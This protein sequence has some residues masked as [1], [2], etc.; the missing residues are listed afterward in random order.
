MRTGGV[1]SH[2]FAPMEARG[3]FR[4]QRDQLGCAGWR[5]RIGPEPGLN[6]S[7]NPAVVSWRPPGGPRLV[8][9][10]SG[11]RL[12]IASS[13]RSRRPE[14]PANGVPRHQHDA[15]LVLCFMT[16]E[17]EGGEIVACGTSSNGAAGAGCPR[18][19]AQGQ[20]LAEVCV[21][22]LPP[23]QCARVVS[24]TVKDP[25]GNRCAAASLGGRGR[26]RCRDHGRVP[27]RSGTGRRRPAD[28]DRGSAPV[29]MLAITS[30]CTVTL[31]SQ[32]M[33]SA[34]T[35]LP[36]PIRTLAMRLRSLLWSTPS[37]AQLGGWSGCQLVGAV[38]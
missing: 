6:P 21:A 12:P 23:N 15:T 33:T 28:S 34:T 35:H 36:T 10:S 38:E 1:R 5:P 22:W 31:L 20:A 3:F 26:A 29:G 9:P 13:R 25:A 18:K 17:R 8:R 2:Y 11:F 16:Y 32:P 37:A 27:H 19:G 30:D 4:R 24:S 14:T 7:Q